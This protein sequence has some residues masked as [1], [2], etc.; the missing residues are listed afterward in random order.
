MDGGVR[1][2]VPKESADMSANEDRRVTSWKTYNGIFNTSASLPT[3][4]PDGACPLV[5]RR[6]GPRLASGL[7]IGL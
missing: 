3:F 7:T 5:F 4:R 6:T 2:S 1:Q